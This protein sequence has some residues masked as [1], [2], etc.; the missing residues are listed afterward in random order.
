MEP[1]AYLG[2]VAVLAAGLGA[3]EDAAPA[4][5]AVELEPV[6]VSARR[7]EEDP[8]RVPQALTR[9]SGAELEG[10][11]AQDLAALD[12]LAPNLTLY[13][14]RAFNGSLTAY[15][16]GIGQFDPV[17]G[18]EPGVAVY[19]DDV[20][21]ARPQGA[22]LDV[23]DVERVEVLRGPQGTLFGRNALGGAIRLLTRAP[24]PEF[25][26]RLGLAAGS[27]DR[28]DGRLVLNLPVSA[29]LCTRLALGHY[30]RD[31]YGRNLTSGGQVS[32]RDAA[33][34]RLN[35]LWS[36]HPDLELRLAYDRYRDRS[37]PRGARRLDVY[38]PSIDPD[39]TPPDPGRHDVR[40]EA[41]ERM[42]LDSEGASAT[43]DWALAPG[44]RLRSVSAWRRGDSQAV[45][46]ME[47]LARPHWVLGRAFEERQYSQ[48]FQ[49]HHERPGQRVVA[50]L[51][52]FDGLERGDGRSIGR[53]FPPTG[54]YRAAGSVATRSAALYAD[55]IGQLSPRWQLEL[56]LR[57]SVERK[58]ARADNGYYTDASYGTA[59]LVTTRLRDHAW[60][61]EPTPR[62]ALAWQAGA[63]TLLY[64]QAARGYKG[65]SYNV[66]ANALAYPE[67]V[68]PLDAETVLSYE[69]G[70]KG[71]WRQGRLEWSAA[72]FHNDYRD[73]QLSVLTA[74]SNDQG[75]FPDFR[76]AG[77]GTTRGLE[78]EWRA[79]LAPWLRWSGHAG[80][81]DT[82]YDRYIDNGLDVASSRHFPNAPRWTAG[83]AL[84]ASWSLGNGARLQARVDGRYQAQ[85]RPTTDLDPRLLQPGYVLWNAGLAWTAPG[86]RWELAL[87]GENLGDTAYRTSGF[88]YASGIITGYYGPPRTWWLDL[89]LPLRGRH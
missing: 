38:P 52:L 67:S 63:D 57:H 61:H 89:S 49:L 35:A 23:L 85:T 82:R 30:Q 31:G 13:P 76:N 71:R 32:A 79:Q 25:G 51:Y 1:G 33:V 65:G 45:L 68:H 15:V 7:H 72:L 73:I 70:A 47:S 77:G 26:G 84:L 80:Y 36:P 55:W 16:R 42:D 2:V 18:V 58:Q 24:E 75:S 8:Q 74:R 12:R 41:D 50:G 19:I 28:H 10:M 81:L 27:H 39:Q 22:L 78:L 43:V 21:L 46:D 69:L 56:G 34:G 29:S 9:A 3:Q 6:Q 5:A 88:V 37:G 48:E 20:Q 40:S 59:Q 4:R 66:R 83:S 54:F 60:Y 53:N 17:W 11:G 14:A 87:R 64:A 44:W 86:G 62:L